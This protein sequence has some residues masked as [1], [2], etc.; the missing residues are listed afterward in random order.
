M[1][2]KAVLDAYE[3]T[4]EFYR[5]Q[6]RNTLKSD[7][8]TFLDFANDKLRSLKKWLDSLNVKSFPDLVNLVAL[9]EFKRR[10]PFNISVYIEEKR[11]MS[12]IKESSPIG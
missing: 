6:F 2:K 3:I 7:K 9:E 12:L 10:L 8:Q 4:P 11:E 1:V 5:R